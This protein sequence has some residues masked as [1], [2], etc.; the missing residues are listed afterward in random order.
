MTT[1]M[2]LGNKIVP[3]SGNNFD[4]SYV[5]YVEYEDSKVDSSALSESAIV[6][7]S[8]KGKT[9]VTSDQHLGHYNIIRYCDRPFATLEEMNEVLI[10]NWNSVV[11]PEDTVY[12]LGDLAFGKGA[13]TDYWLDYLNGNIIFFRGN[14]DSSKDIEFFNSAIITFGGVP[15]FLTHDTGNIPDA[16]RGW[17]IHGHHHN[18]EPTEFPFINHRAKT[19]NVSVELTDYTPVNI[20]NILQLVGKPR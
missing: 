11:S 15:F 14:H 16:W 3:L 8:K 6:N 1:S 10:E 13:N 2:K 4:E 17:V 18:N 7:R 20:E 12:F 9:F 5:D 19:I